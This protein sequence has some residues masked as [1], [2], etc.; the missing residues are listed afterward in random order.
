MEI[1]EN[2]EK[3]IIGLDQLNRYKDLLTR[4]SGVAEDKARRA[5]SLPLTSVGFR[6]DI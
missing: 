5:G 2:S 6:S 1:K 4:S 3:Y